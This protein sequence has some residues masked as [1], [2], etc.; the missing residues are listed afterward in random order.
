MVKSYVVGKSV[1]FDMKVW[2]CNVKIITKINETWINDGM[3]CKYSYDIKIC[4]QMMKIQNGYVNRCVCVRIYIF[5]YLFIYL[6]TL[7]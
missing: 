7:T 1:K 6:N 4:H 3:I 2:R 5:I